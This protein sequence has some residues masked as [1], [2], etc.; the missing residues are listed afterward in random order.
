MLKRHELGKA[1]VEANKAFDEMPTA[2]RYD[3]NGWFE[4]AANPLS[5]VGVF[6]YTG[7]SIGAPDPAAQLTVTCSPT[8][9]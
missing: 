7:A 8:Y 3:G 5:K 6:P 1:I 2:R 4:I 9:W